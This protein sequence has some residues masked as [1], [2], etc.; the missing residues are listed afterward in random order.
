MK[1]LLDK[2]N[3]AGLIGASSELKFYYFYEL[4]N[5][6]KDFEAIKKALRD[7]NCRICIEYQCFVDELENH[8]V[9]KLMS[10]LK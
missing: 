5:S 3:L 2:H 7:E 10:I 8:T 1:N 4:Y 9:S 6:G